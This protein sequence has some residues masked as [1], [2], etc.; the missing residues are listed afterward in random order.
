M[1]G[2]ALQI[3]TCKYNIDDAAVTAATDDAEQQKECCKDDS[4]VEQ[5]LRAQGRA[6]RR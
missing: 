6:S 4:R 1:V 3:G 2:M 5:G